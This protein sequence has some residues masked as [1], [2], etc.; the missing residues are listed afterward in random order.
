MLVFFG[1]CSYMRWF[2]R[3]AADAADANTVTVKDYAVRVG[4][5]PPDA[6]GRALREYLTRAAAEGAE[7]QEEPGEVRM[8]MGVR[9]KREEPV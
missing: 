4:G 2:V 9:V 7:E 8:G 1:Y 3:K 5:L 6:S